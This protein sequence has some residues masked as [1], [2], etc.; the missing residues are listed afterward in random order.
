[1]AL[2]LQPGYWAVLFI[3][4]VLIQTLFSRQRAGAGV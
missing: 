4:G 2:N 3:A 1:M